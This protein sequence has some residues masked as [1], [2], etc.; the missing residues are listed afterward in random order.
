MHWFKIVLVVVLG[1]NVILNI[2]ECYGHK[3][4]SSNKPP[5]LAIL[6]GVLLILGIL[7]WL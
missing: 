1:A 6:T 5:V 7:Y 2:A 4:K 3:V